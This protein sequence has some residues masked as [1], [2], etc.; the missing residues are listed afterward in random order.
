[1]APPK[2][3][4]GMRL[5]DEMIRIA[6]V[7]RL[8]LRTC[9]PHN[10]S[11]GKEVNA[12]GLHGLS[13]RRSSARQKRHEELNGIIWRS[14]KRNQLPVSK[15]PAGLARTDGKRP[16]GST[17]IS[18]SQGKPLAWDV[19]VPDTFADSHLKDTSVIA[20]ATANRAADLKCTKYTNITSKHIFAP[21]AMET[22][23]SWNQ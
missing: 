20:G 12:R 21:I 3:S 19:T 17:F 18:W 16:D 23:G 14:I 7:F 2:T 4:I 8:G 11:C 9:E 6:V 13:C 10:C 22:S 1:M 5:S 15:E